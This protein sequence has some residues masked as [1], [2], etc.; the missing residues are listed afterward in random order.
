MEHSFKLDPYSYMNQS[1]SFTIY[2]D[3]YL[4]N[5]LKKFVK[6]CHLMAHKKPCSKHLQKDT[7]ESDNWLLNTAHVGRQKFSFALKNILIHML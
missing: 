1:C 7:N 4:S 6:A 3:S 2:T 5:N